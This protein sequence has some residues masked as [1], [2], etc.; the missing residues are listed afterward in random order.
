MTF[1]GC[2]RLIGDLCANN[3]AKDAMNSLKDCSNRRAKQSAGVKV[4]NCA[5]II[6]NE[7]SK[8]RGL[9]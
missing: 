6:M 1:F 9:M 8:G 5:Q 7:T 4:N 2:E 3:F